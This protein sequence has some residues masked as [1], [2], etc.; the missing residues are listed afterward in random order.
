MISDRIFHRFLASVAIGLLGLASQEAAAQDFPSKPIKV[1]VG[2]AVGGG[3]DAIGRMLADRLGRVFKQPVVV[4]NKV[5][6]NGNIAAEFV[7]NAPADGH[8]LL[9]VIHTHVTNPGAYA[10]LRYD[11]LKDFQPVGLAAS[12]PLLFL[13][14][15]AFPPNNMQEL[16]AYARAN[17]G[18]ATFGTPGMGSPAHLAMEMLKSAAK[19]DIMIVHYK[20]AGAAESDLIAGHIN[21]QGSTLNQGMPL[22]KAGRVKVLAQAGAKRSEQAPDTPTITESG[23]P[24]FQSNSWFALLAPTKTPPAIIVRLNQELNLALRDPEVLVRFRAAGAE[25]MS[26]TPEEAAK[27]MREEQV[28]WLKVM[29]EV[30]IKPE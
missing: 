26:S 12:T 19:M 15:P 9:F 27:Y 14:N 28:K 17:P 24:G 20:G 18:K 11:P 2:Y 16:I 1:V 21:M 23:L 5:G 30:G 6:A 8:T 13:A 7:A 22:A 3:T 25:P 10:N 4:E 29:K